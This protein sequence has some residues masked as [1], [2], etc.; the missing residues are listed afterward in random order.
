MR[1]TGGV[2]VRR[3]V[4]GPG[5]KLPLR[6]SPDFLREQAFAVLAPDLAGAVFLDLFAGTGVNAVEAL[7]RGAAR[8]VLVEQDPRAAA[9]ITANLAR[10]GA[11]QRADVLVSPAAEAIPILAHRGVRC[12]V[13]WCDPPFAEFHLGTAAL[14]LARALEVLVEGAL[15][16]LEVPPRTPTAVE[17]FEVVRTLRGAVLLRVLGR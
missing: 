2:W 10:F 17:G 16:V 12:E 9:I 3:Q 15:V 14:A 11:S 7:S 1:V 6:P 8:G 5:P 4:Q 13:G